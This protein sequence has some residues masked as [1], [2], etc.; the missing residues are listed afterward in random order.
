MP[1]PNHPSYPAGHSTLSSAAVTILVNYFPEARDKWTML[2]EEGGMSRIWGG[3]HYMQDHEAGE[4][5]GKKV[6]EVA[7]QG[8]QQ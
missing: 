6:A 4:L 5:L 8:T 7:L 3:I 1:T 2:G